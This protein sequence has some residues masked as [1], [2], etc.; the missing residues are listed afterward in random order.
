VIG[1]RDFKTALLD[2]RDAGMRLAGWH[3]VLTF[4]ILLLGA[5]VLLGELSVWMAAAGMAALAA[6]AFVWPW[7]SANPPPPREQAGFDTGRD[8]TKEATVWQTIL[9]GMHDLGLLLDR[10]SNLLAFN[11]RADA[12]PQSALGRHISHWKRAPAL[13]RAIEDALGKSEQRTAE[14]REQSPVKRSA[15]AL[16][17]PLPSPTR[18]GKPAVLV[19]FRDLTGEDQ[20]SRLRAD[21]VANASHEL[22]TPLA[23]LKGFVETL[24]GAAKDDPGARTEFLKIMQQ[25][26]DRMSRLIEDLLSLSRIEMRE[27]VAPT[28]VADLG[29][30]VEEAIRA[31]EPAAEDA[32]VTIERVIAPG[33]WLVHGER[34]ELVQVAQNLIQN[35]IKYGKR[36]G[37]IIVSI[38]REAERIAFA[39]KDDGI[40]IAPEH[41]PRLTER[42]YRVSAKDSRERG[43]TGLGLAIVKHIVNRHRGELRIRSTV[44]VG[45]TFTVLLPPAPPRK[46]N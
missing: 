11:A 21:F 12:P 25:Q 18:P 27:H 2:I 10:D 24:Q 33:D 34:D 5:F 8:A 40:G 22:R 45:S 28:S 26:A 41:L 14:L 44:R 37:K 9:D 38:E 30:V 15:I 13:L 16:V 32:G 3:P 43:G 35:A 19:T 7:G 42:F 29:A 36:N 31:L 1:N 20:L 23:S 46:D 39:V 6:A 4:G 17:T